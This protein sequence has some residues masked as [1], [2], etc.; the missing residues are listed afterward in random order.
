MPGPSRHAA[1]M[2]RLEGAGRRAPVDA[3]LREHRQRGKGLVRAPRNYVRD[4]G[5]LHALLDLERAYP[6]KALS[7]PRPARRFSGPF[8]VPPPHLQAALNS[9]PVSIRCAST[10][11][12]ASR[13]ASS[14]RP[15]HAARLGRGV[16]R[17]ALVG[18]RLRRLRHRHQVQ[19]GA[20]R[21]EHLARLAHRLVDLGRHV[22]EEHRLPE[23]QAQPRTPRRRP[24]RTL[25]VGIGPLEASW[26]RAASST[27]RVSG[28]TLSRVQ[29]SG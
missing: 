12:S 28:T 7:P 20:Q 1:P 22:V 27:E 18:K 21:P 29:L 25:A 4:S 17:P 24:P 16:A 3:L 19:V 10:G 26:A 2:T 23:G 13:C 9:R 15:V 14:R 11:S 5:L 6:F 8:S